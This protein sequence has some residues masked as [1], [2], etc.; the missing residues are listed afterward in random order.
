MARFDVYANTGKSK[1]ATPFLID[2][3]SNVISGLATRIV[4]PLHDL[5]TT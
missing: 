1:K 5:S 4:I 2:V 3:Q